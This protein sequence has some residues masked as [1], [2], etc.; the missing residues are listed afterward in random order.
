MMTHYENAGVEYVSG[1]EHQYE[2]SWL[3]FRLFNAQRLSA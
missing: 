3:S 1:M 2:A